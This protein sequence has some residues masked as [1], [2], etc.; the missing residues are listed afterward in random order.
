[1]VVPLTTDSPAVLRLDVA[2]FELRL[3]KSRSQAQQAI[4]AGHVLLNGERVKPSHDLRAGDRVTLV[5]G[6]TRHTLE[7]VALPGRSVSKEAAKSLVREI[8]E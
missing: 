7:V 5:S 4:A 6:S 3:F 2:L 8:A 1:V